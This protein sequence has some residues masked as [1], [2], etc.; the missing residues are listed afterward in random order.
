MRKPRNISLTFC[1]WCGLN[2]WI[3]GTE[4]TL[5]YIGV[6]IDILQTQSSAFSRKKVWFSFSQLLDDTLSRNE[7]LHESSSSRNTS[8]ESWH[9]VTPYQNDNDVRSEFPV[10]DIFSTGVQTIRK[11]TREKGSQYH[12]KMIK[13]KLTQTIDWPQLFMRS[14]S[15]QALPIPCTCADSEKTD[16]FARSGKS[17]MASIFHFLWQCVY[18]WKYFK[19]LF[20]EV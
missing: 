10:K 7:D 16:K 19:L 18:T 13:N 1:F 5:T 11:S 3:T 12:N 14:V 17:Y 2:Q 6:N 9:E 20:Q 15:T 4:C 8:I